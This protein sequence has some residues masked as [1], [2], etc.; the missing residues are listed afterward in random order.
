MIRII[1]IEREFGCGCSAIRSMNMGLSNGQASSARGRNSK[2]LEKFP[3]HGMGDC[4]QTV[5]G[6][7]FLINVV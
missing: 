6:V 4:F 7:E 2:R 1:T 3:L 5:M